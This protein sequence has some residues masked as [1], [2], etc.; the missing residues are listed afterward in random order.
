V[1]EFLVMTGI[2]K[3]Y[4]GVVALAGVD[5]DLRESEVHVILGE[6]G[7]GKSTLIKVL[8]GVVQ[9]DAGEI[10][11]DG[12]PARITSAADAKAR[13]IATIHQELALVPQLSVAENLLLGQLPRRF[14]IVDRRALMRQAEE[15]LD[16]VGATVDPLRIVGTM[17]VAQQQMVEIAKA[18]SGEVRVLIMDE[19]TASLSGQETERLF[20]LV[21]ELAGRGVGVIF[22]S[23]HLEEVP[24]IGGRVTVLRDGATVGEVPATTSRAE[25]VR[26][27]VGRTIDAQYP[28][29]PRKPQEPLLTVEHLTR[30]GVFEDVSF[31]VHA[32]EVLGIAG[33]IGAGRTELVRSIFGADPVDDGTVTVAGK[34]LRHGSPRAAREVGL[35]LVPED[36]KTQ[37]LVLGLSV[38]ENLGLATLDVVSHGGLIDRG[39]VRHRADRMVDSLGVH[40]PNLDVAVRTLSGGNQQK[41]AIGKWLLAESK[42]LI[43]DEPTRGVDVGAKVEIYQLIN[44]LTAAGGAV[45]LVSSELVEVLSMSDRL[46]VM[47]EGRITGELVAARATQE[48]VMEL[49]VREK[50]SDVA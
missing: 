30:H 32:G 27:M 1:T 24:E 25:L 41:V 28:H 5:F 2:R 48:K 15:L 49:A 33:L 31:E 36:R 23:H 12:S 22:I 39:A 47:A 18:L 46:L 17:G 13:G 7:A 50:E 37:G 44:G 19:P 11:I 35:G 4:P 26:L 14:G 38:A 29:E 34:R 21:R 20:E 10:R 8:G 40:T 45:V 3:T 16:R 43:L 42:V 6:N 9:P